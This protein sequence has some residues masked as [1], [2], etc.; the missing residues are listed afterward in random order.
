MRGRIEHKR[1]RCTP[2]AVGVLWGTAGFL[3]GAA[4]S[5]YLAA[6]QLTTSGLPLPLESPASGCTSLAL[7]R[8]SGNTREGPCPTPS[9]SDMLTAFLG[10]PRLP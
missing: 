4:F 9:L 8:H 6:P 10:D 1:D 5:I 2:M 7:D 3:L